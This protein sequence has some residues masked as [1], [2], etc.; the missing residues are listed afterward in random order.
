MDGYF[1]FGKARIIPRVRGGKPDN[2]LKSTM[3]EK[4]REANRN[5]GVKQVLVLQ[6]ICAAVLMILAGGLAVFKGFHAGQGVVASPILFDRLM[7][8]LYGSMLAI[9]GTLLN[10]RSVRQAGEGAG[11]PG[12]AGMVPVYVGLLNK[13]VIVGGG[14]AFGLIGLGLEPIWL[15]T[16]YLVVQLSTLLV[17]LQPE[18]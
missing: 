10:A 15:V 9:A 7:S 5:S 16:G 6:C 18:R 2:S 17:L 11:E 1:V 14:V 12:L 13:L 4:W 8:V 3:H